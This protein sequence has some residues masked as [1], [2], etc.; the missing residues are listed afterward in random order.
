MVMKLLSG[1]DPSPVD[2][3]PPTARRPR[4]LIIADHAGRCIPAALAGLGLPEAERDR[5]IGWDIGIEGVARSLAAMLGAGALMQRYSRLVIDCNRA[6][7]DP[8]AIVEQS[9]GTVIPGNRNLSPEV[10]DARVREVH[11][12][13]HAAIAAALMRLPHDA[14]LIALHSFTPRMNGADRPWHCG[15]LHLHDSPLSRCMLALLAAEGDLIVGDN[16]PYAM[17]GT[18]Y[19]VP[20]HAVAAGRDYVEIEIRQ[21][22]IADA[23]AQAQWAARL[24][25]VLTVALD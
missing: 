13:Y 25:R 6:P 11:A 21:D 7:D 19:T 1:D 24:A 3:V 9:D 23:A 14:P 17:A 20:L 18:D 4:G 2:A 12:P 10:R 22:L 8:R 15:V 16:Q 5:H